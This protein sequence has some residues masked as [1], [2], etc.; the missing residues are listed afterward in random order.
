M[1]ND[2]VISIY[3]NPV[4]GDVMTISSNISTNAN[5][6]IVNMMGSEVANGKLNNNQISVAT[7]PTGIYMI[8]VYDNGKTASKRFIKK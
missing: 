4:T 7:L 2:A 3:P 6:K 8:E 5:Y 1:N